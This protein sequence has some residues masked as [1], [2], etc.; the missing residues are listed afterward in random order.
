MTTGDK[1]VFEVFAERVRQ[2]FATAR[3]WAYGSRVHETHSAESDLDVCVVLDVLDEAAD[4]TIIDIAWQVGF[5]RDVLIS[6]VTFSREEFDRGPLRESAL[7]QTV[8]REGIA[9]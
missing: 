2:R 6:T 1:N 4:K 5:D 7:V 9:A 3:I 8:L